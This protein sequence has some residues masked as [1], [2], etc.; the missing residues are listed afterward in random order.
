[1]A[2]AER[3]KLK[4]APQ[5]RVE[6]PTSWLL[7]AGVLA[8]AGMII[9]ATFLTYS[10]SLSGDF[11]F[12]DDAHLTDNSLIKAGDGLYRFWFTREP[13]D[14]YPV[15]NATLWIEWRLWGMQST[16]YHV[17]NLVLHLLA[18]M[19]IW[20]LLRRLAIPGAFLAAAL[21]AIHPVNVETVAWVAQRKSLLAMVFFLLSI[22]WYLRAEKA[23]P[24]QC[25]GARPTMNRW[26]CFSAGRVCACH[27]QQGIGGDA[28]CRTLAARVVGAAPHVARPRSHRTV[29]CGG[30][31]PGPG[32]RLVPNARYG[33]SDSERC[34]S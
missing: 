20:A 7:R 34:I 16:G 14:Y 22:Q 17:T 5:F 13:V 10:P 27:A 8:G 11:I 25:R 28:T 15:S 26:Y 18:A 6:C 21:F 4:P 12:D 32:E 30:G 24:A 19:L 9:L 33:S 23:L 29:L 1:M 3:S 2:E 31:G